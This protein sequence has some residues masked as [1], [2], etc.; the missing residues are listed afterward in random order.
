MAIKSIDHLLCVD[1]FEKEVLSKMLPFITH[2]SL[3]LAMDH[4]PMIMIDK[5]NVRRMSIYMECVET[6]SLNNVF[7][8]LLGAGTMGRL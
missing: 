5:R 3:R 7:E 6:A 1:M 2:P 4:F 8:Q